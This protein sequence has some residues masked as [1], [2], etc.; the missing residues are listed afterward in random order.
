MSSER[1]TCFISNHRVT[2]RDSDLSPNWGAS[3]LK[4]LVLNPTKSA[5]R[6]VEAHEQSRA[7]GDSEVP[8][9]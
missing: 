8:S 1:F 9:R 7:R 4:A 6:K 3:F 2:I 5:G